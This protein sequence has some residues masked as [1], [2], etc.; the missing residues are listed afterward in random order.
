MTTGD[1]TFGN[2]TFSNYTLETPA[3]RCLLALQAALR[4]KGYSPSHPTM[5]KVLRLKRSM[6]RNKVRRYSFN[7]VPAKAESPAVPAK[8]ANA[9]NDRSELLIPILEQVTGLAFSSKD[10]RV[11]SSGHF[12]VKFVLTGTNSP[13]SLEKTRSSVAERVFQEL[14]EELSSFSIQ[15]FISQ[16]TAG[17]TTLSVQCIYR[18]ADATKI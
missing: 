17:Q 13:V 8:L 3:E 14:K 2:L 10:S 15:P 5:K 6:S 7:L 11:T 18:G 16:S 1:K 9:K 12:L 4:V